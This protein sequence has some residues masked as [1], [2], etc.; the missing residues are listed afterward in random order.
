MSA[1]TLMSSPD[2]FMSGVTF[3]SSSYR[4]LCELLDFRNSHEF[5]SVLSL[6]PRS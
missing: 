6:A 4:F 3:R 2:D 5:M 1:I